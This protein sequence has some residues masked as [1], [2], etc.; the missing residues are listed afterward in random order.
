MPKPHP[1]GSNNLL[2]DLPAEA[3]ERR[4]QIEEAI[5]V[6]LASSQDLAEVALRI[7]QAVRRASAV[8]PVLIPALERVSLIRARLTHLQQSLSAYWHAGHAHR[9]E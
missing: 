3:K 8:S 2:G 4:D 5:A 1:T 7:E 6:M 9:W